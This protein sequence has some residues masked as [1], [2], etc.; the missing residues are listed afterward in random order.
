[1][2]AAA[3]GEWEGRYT[4]PTPPP[5]G[6]TADDLDRIPGLP[7][8]T[9]LIDGGLFFSSPQADFHRA[10]LHLLENALAEAAPDAFQVVRGA[11]VRLG[12]RDRPEPDLMVVAHDARTG[13]GGTWYYPSD[14]VLTVEVVSEDSEWRDREIKPRK[15]AGARIRRYWRVEKNGAQPVVCV[16]ELDPATRSYTIT[17]IHHHR[18]ELTEPFPVDIDLTAVRRRP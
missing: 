8:H 11:A 18:L 7:P 13:P 6:W 10:A 15:Y 14:V 12:G 16:Y 9:E 5:G 2:S 17:G 3:E 1:M 4:Y